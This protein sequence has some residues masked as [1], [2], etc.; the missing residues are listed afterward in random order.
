MTLGLTLPNPGITDVIQ[1]LHFDPM[2]VGSIY[3]I[4]TFLRVGP[5][6]AA[7]F[8]VSFTSNQEIIYDRIHF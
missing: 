7:E 8:D 6:A 4:T 1:S 5:T 3:D 2:C